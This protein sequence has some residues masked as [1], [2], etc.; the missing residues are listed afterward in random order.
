MAS[1]DANN[2]YKTKGLG[3][4]QNMYKPENGGFEIEDTSNFDMPNSQDLKLKP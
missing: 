1:Y 4:I 3:E 2:L